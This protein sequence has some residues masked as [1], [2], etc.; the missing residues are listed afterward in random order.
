MNVKPILFSG[1]MVRALLAGTKTQTRR[2]VKPRWGL[3]PIEN[4]KTT[5][6]DLFS[7]RFDD[8]ESWGWPYADDGAP[9]SLACWKDLLCPYGEA[10]DLIWVRETWGRDDEDGKVFYS[11]DIGRDDDTGDFERSRLEGAPGYRWRPSIHMQRNYS[12]LTL[13]T[14]E[15][16]VQRLQ[17]ISEADSEAE[18]CDRSDCYPHAFRD[19]YA[20]LW[21][22]ING[23][24]SWDANPWVWVVSFEVIKANVDQ[25]LKQVA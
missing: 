7:G 21:D 1:P 14:T 8:P 11:A 23:A 19:S 12:R 5:D 18:G 24:G 16:R 22:R 10:G 9:M 4:L 6:P 3:G 17:D 20:A 15:V 2:V 13:R 25:V